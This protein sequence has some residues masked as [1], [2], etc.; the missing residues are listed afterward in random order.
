MRTSTVWFLITAM[1]VVSVAVL[2]FVMTYR[3]AIPLVDP[4]P[5]VPDYGLRALIAGIT[6]AAAVA[7]GIG[8]GVYASTRERDRR[9]IVG[10]TAAALLLGTVLGTILAFV[11]SA[12]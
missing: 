3:F 12:R 2:A 4:A 5:P 1:T 8:A 7:G 10:W 6:M 9:R 11:S